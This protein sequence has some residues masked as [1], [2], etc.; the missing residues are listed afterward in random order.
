MSTHS[1]KLMFKKNIMEHRAQNMLRA[2]IFEN[3]RCYFLFCYIAREENTLHSHPL[4]V[5][6]LI[7]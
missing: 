5:S 3:K 7:E 6:F 2:N 4:F 1:A